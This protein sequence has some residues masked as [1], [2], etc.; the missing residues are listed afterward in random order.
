M[1][2]RFPPFVVITFSFLFSLNG[3]VTPEV[4]TNYIASKK[5]YELRSLDVAIMPFLARELTESEIEDILEEIVENLS[6]KGMLKKNSF[7]VKRRNNTKKNEEVR[8]NSL[9]F[10]ITSRILYKEIDNDLLEKWQSSWEVYIKNKKI[11][12]NTLK[13]ICT[14][15]GVTTVLQF[16]VTDVRTTKSAHRKTIAETEVEIW[17]TLFFS[18]GEILLVGKSI[19]SQ[20]N[21][22]SGQLQPKPIEAIEPAVDDIL[23]KIPF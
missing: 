23:A 3:C 6:N 10:Y 1:I 20:A 18:D 13:E 22:W 15:M 19:A 17:Y 12:T 16:A 4:A 14:K 5:L 2:C 9:A 7:A 21:A 8:G 11:D